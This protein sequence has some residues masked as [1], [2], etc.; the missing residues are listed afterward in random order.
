VRNARRNLRFGARFIFL[1][2]AL[3]NERSLAQVSKGSLSG[4][5]TD[6]QNAVVG[7]AK[8][9][10][11]NAGSNEEFNT[12]SDSAGLF[13]SNLLPIGNYR[14]EISAIG[15]KKLLVENVLVSAGSDEGLGILQI[16]VGDVTTTVEVPWKAALLERTEA[17]VSSSFG[18]DTLTSF[19]GILENNGLDNL[20]LTVAGVVN[21]RDLGVSSSNGAEFAVNGLRGRNND[22]QIDGQ[23]NN[24]NLAAGPSLAMSDPEFVQEYQIT[25]SNFRAE[26]GRNSG[27]VV[28]ILT[29]SGSNSL[30]GSLYATEGNWRFNTLSSSQKA[31][32]G[33]TQV[34]AFND[35]FLGGTIGGAVVKNKLFFFGGVDS[36]LIN[37]SAVFGT[38]QLTP[39][40]TGIATLAKCFPES[41]AVKVLETYGP[42][43][44][45]AGNP[46][47]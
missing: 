21:S 25:T 28:N 37:Q 34:P 42:Y 47:P 14:V 19:P 38:G 16:E 9:K 30:H 36:D 2:C 35:A 43:A 8:V 26:Y 46:T 5:V 4:I 6:S 32:E 27:S 1:L 31:F 7:G 18:E 20:A 22:Q 33:L 23:N 3:G 45:R 40:P 11:T 15:F 12:I 39:T 24:D 29:K 10:A 17:Q 41:T 44:V 13:R